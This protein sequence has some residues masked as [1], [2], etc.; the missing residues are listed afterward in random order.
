MQQSWSERFLYPFPPFCLISRI[1]QKVIREKTSMIILVT[2]TWHSQPWYPQLLHMSIEKPVLLPKQNN[3]L[4]NPLG[5]PHPLVVNKTLR[6]AAWKISGRDY[7]CQGFL[8][9]LQNLSLNLEGIHLQAILNRLGE[10]G[11]AGVIQFHVM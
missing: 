4:K 3:L 5:N 2:P 8:Q 7:L 10:S 9:Q 6:V 1:L 11:L